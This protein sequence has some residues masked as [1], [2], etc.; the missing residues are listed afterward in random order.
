[1]YNYNILNNSFPNNDHLKFGVW[2]DLRGCLRCALEEKRSR[3][4]LLK[5]PTT[6]FGV[7]MH[8]YIM[9]IHDIIAILYI[10]LISLLISTA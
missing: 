4:C 1:M 9:Y 10:F 2:R 6:V 5:S 7:Y 8:A 3:Y